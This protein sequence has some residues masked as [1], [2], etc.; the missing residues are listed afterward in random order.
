MVFCYDS[1][2]RLNSFYSS[3]DLQKDHQFPLNDNSVTIPILRGRQRYVDI[4][5]FSESIA[6]A[7]TLFQSTQDSGASGGIC[8]SWEVGIWPCYPAPSYRG[9]TPVT[10]CCQV[11]P[12]SS[13]TL[14]LERPLRSTEVSLAVPVLGHLSW[15][16]KVTFHFLPALNPVINTKP[17]HI[18]PPARFLCLL[19]QST[20]T[21]W[22]PFL[23]PHDDHHVHLVL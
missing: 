11:E 4:K 18:L 23:M 6:W 5:W 19:K 3:I 20:Q 15:K 8:W 1:P 7:W 10:H 21:W 9:P 13:G 12:M 2:C 22:N 16:R 14:G 17:Y